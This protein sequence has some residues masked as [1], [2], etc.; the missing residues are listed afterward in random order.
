MPTAAGL[1]YFAH[2]AENYARPPAILI[3]GA[4]GSH[5]SWPPQI[6]RLSRQ[7]MYAMDLPAHG[8]SAGIGHHRVEDYADHIRDFIKALGLRAAVLIGHS[9]G[10]AIALSLAI[11]FPDQIL[12]LGLLGG[13]PR[14]H[15]S[16]ALLQ[17]ASNPAT[18]RDTVRRL[19]D[20]SFTLHAGR[21]MKELV[22]QRMAGTRPTVLYGDLLACEAFNATESLSHISAPTL[23]L[24][25]AEDKMTPPINS[26]SL[27]D[28]IPG[29]RLTL[30]PEAGHMLMLE[31]TDLTATALNEFLNGIRYQPGQ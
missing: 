3:H 12:G 11:R 20:Y 6:R 18:F 24:C 15:V 30:V 23:I 2:E 26:E 5:L 27:R 10:S 14:L 29:A 25:G 1:Y 13:G 9:M 22:I 4:G 21:R 28:Q 19:V 16:P 7:R 31:Q 8:K 17:S